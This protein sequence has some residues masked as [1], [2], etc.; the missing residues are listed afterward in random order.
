MKVVIIQPPL[1][2]LNTPYPSGAYLSA[3]FKKLAD[4]TV[5]GG[6]AERRDLHEP[7]GLC[8]SR[9]KSVKW[10]DLSERVFNALFCRS[11]L[12]TLFTLSSEK[13][14]RLADEAENQ[15][16]D[17]TAW[18]LRR[19]VSQ[20]ELWIS[21]IDT[22]VRI[23]CGKDRELSHEFVRSAHV[24]RGR[25]METFLESLDHD[26]GIDDAQLLAS[27]ALADLA[28][29][30]NYVFDR[31]FSLIRYAEAVSTGDSTFAEIEETL[32]APFLKTF[33]APLLEDLLEELV[34]QLVPKSAGSADSVNPEYLF[35]I[36]VPFGG[37]F[38]AALLTC[39]M[40]KASFGSRAVISLGGGYINTALREIRDPRIFEYADYISYDKGYGFYA[41]L[42]EGTLSEAVENDAEKRAACVGTGLCYKRGAWTVLRPSEKNRQLE[43]VMTRNLC[44]DFSD[45]DFSRYPKVSD[46]TNAMHR[47]WTDGS[48][49]KA[50]LAYGCYWHRC[51]FCDTTL[52]YVCKYKPVNIPS[53]YDGLYKEAQKSS[54]YGIHFVDEAAP[55]VLLEQFAIENTRNKKRRLSFWGNIRFEKTFT[56]DVA[57]ILAHGGMT[58]VSGGIEIASGEGL[59]DVNKGIDIDS[60]VGACAAFKEAGI[61]VHAYMIYGFYN[62]TPQMLIDSAETL[63]QLFAAGLIDSAFWHKFTLTKYSTVYNDWK[64]GRCKD[65]KPLPPKKDSFAVYELRF[66][67]E[68]KSEKYGAPLMTAL[69]A[70]MHGRGFEKPVQKWFPFSMPKPSIVPNFIDKAIE[71]YERKRD[72]AFAEKYPVHRPAAKEVDN[73]QKRDSGEGATSGEQKIEGDFSRYIWIGGKPIVV[74]RGK[75]TFIEWL[76]MGEPFSVQVPSKGATDTKEA[77]KAVKSLVSLNVNK[78]GTITQ[79]DCDDSPGNEEAVIP[80]W[81][82]RAVRGKGLAK[83]I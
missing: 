14:L 35:C 79:T 15:G 10:Y 73:A 60:L 25:R 31:N 50:F 34:A 11:G 37:T 7:G 9:I 48:W 53:L 77:E 55:P 75:A 4:G 2:Q 27:F 5:A 32:D 71:R 64:N 83:R 33:Y 17:E 22:I 41:G 40:L 3:F 30:I 72:A 36:S 6:D 43:E 82:F 8:G 45:I 49:L 54:V 29:Y 70:W 62:E 20:S 74:Q 13:A 42:L 76:Y 67:G 61:L 78:D 52:D 63:R 44:P 59:S 66:E 68:Q 24:P 80:E 58:G 65:I 28:D 57:D 56:R 69:D 21:W 19:Y 38:S 26:V 39:R 1:V 18:N 23:L 16:D 47:I 12:E 46:D 81:L 51:A